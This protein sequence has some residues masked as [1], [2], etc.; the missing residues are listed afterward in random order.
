[1]PRRLGVRNQ[2]VNLGAVAGPNA[3]GGRDVDPSVTD[4]CR[5]LGERPGLFSISI[6]KSTAMASGVPPYVETARW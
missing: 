6:T 4:R 2:D 3:G 1:M 5:D